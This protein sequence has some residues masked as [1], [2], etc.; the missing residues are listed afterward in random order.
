VAK[1]F[2]AMHVLAFE[3]LVKEVG[4]TL[5]SLEREKDLRENAVHSSENL[6]L[7]PSFLLHSVIII[8]QPDDRPGRFLDAIS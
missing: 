8:P 5:S 7:P 2:K 4:D 1:A 3:E 6:P